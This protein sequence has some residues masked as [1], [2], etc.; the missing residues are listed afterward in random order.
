MSALDQVYDQ[1]RQGLDKLA[2]VLE[3][4]HAQNAFDQVLQ[5]NF[6]VTSRDFSFEQ[7]VTPLSTT[8][9]VVIGALGYL[10]ML[11]VLEK[12]VLKFGTLNKSFLN[13]IK[14]F[15][16]LFLSG[17]SLILFTLL[18]E[19]I[20]P[21]LIRN[22][23]IWSI[24]DIES[25]SDPTI[26]LIYYLNYL[27]KYYE[28][29]DTALLILG[30]SQ[31]R[32]LHVYHHS[33]TMVLC[34]TQIVGHTSVQW[35]P[36]LL[37]LGVHVVMYFYYFLTAIGLRPWWRNCVTW[38][39]I[40]QFVGDIIA[41]YIASYLHFYAPD[42]TKFSFGY[43]YCYGTPFSATGGSL[44]LTTY[45]YLFIGLLSPSEK[46]AAQRSAAAKGA[47]AAIKKKN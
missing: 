27:S 5:Q 44:L 43:D 19:N 18:F 13:F 31:T 34:Y 8:H 38:L 28:L 32:F 3:Q 7:G 1:A 40:F 14:I 23:F 25:F 46:P 37:N 4:R 20:I 12:F 26:M 33:L 17:V 41:C 30:G 47:K 24:C 42:P 29:I 10:A 22:G 16:N 9:S 6:Q 35:V 39:Q 11:Y 15:H 36:I 2:V 45:L 21:R